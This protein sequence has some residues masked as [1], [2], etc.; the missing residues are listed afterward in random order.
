MPRLIV[1]A[2]DAVGR[3]RWIP[4]TS[5]DESNATLATWFGVSA[6]NLPVV[7]PNI[8]RFAKPNLGFMR[9][10]SDG[11]GQTGP[12]PIGPSV[13]RAISAERLIGRV[14]SGTA[15]YMT[16]LLETSEF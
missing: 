6:A 16:F 9:W 2:D 11:S 10:D 15:V 13:A 3:G 7:L 14:K 12:F 1:T 5:V 4:S 8:G